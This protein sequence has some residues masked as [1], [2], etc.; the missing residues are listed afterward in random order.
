M[1]GNEEIAASGFRNGGPLLEIQVTIIVPRQ[2]GSE[3]P[4]VEP[5]GE[6][7]REPE[8]DVLLENSSEAD[9]P[10]ILAAMAGIDDDGVH[11]P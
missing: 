7:L 6:N 8:V 1:D 4:F 10:G 5:L 2:N 11:G 9:R 3:S